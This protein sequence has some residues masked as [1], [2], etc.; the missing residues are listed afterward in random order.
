[1]GATSGDQGGVAVDLVESWRTWMRAQSWSER[2]V[3]DR[4][5]LVLRVGRLSERQPEQLDVDD[6]LAFLSSDS[7]QASTRQT[8]HV[9]LESWF[10]WME[11]VGIRDDNPMR[12]LSIPKAKRRAPRT[13]ATAHVVRLLDT[14]MHA[15]TRTMCLLAA[16]QGLR[17]SEVAKVRGIDIDPVAR[18]LRV[19]GKGNVDAV[20]P[21]HPLIEVEAADYG[22]GWWFPQW[23]PN[24][25]GDAGGHVL[26]RS[27]STI[28]AN[29]MHRARIP[30]SAHSLRHWYATE[31]LRA[32]V[33][34]RIV[35]ELMRHASL[36]TTQRY[37]H[38]DDTQRRAGL[39]LLP[40]A[41]GGTER[42][43]WHYAAA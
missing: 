6:V 30:G 7:F 36:A 42:H 3:E 39:L 10:R 20:L 31:L 43:A 18:E 4:I 23:K 26:G 12:R 14:R 2:T 5:D 8:Y 15:R 41:T 1:M 38:V 24:R 40:D 13:I 33:D 21:L 28:I 25:T 19:V 27:V 35:M 37:L 9:N 29:A 11:L 34:C 32:G 22:P 16:Y 17:V